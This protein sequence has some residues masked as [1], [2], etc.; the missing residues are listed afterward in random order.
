MALVEGEHDS[1]INRK[2]EGALERGRIGKTASF[3]LIEEV[4]DLIYSLFI[5]PGGLASI[6]RSAASILLASAMAAPSRA[7]N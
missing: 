6:A 5:L 3:D 1:G 4:H 2:R 7:A